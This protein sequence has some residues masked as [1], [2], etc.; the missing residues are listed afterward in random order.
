MPH[1]SPKD[2]IAFIVHGHQE[3]PK[4]AIADFLRDFT[5]LDPAIL[6]ELPKGSRTII[7]VLETVGSN[8][9]FAIVLLTG[10]DEGGISGGGNLQM[11]A[12]QNVIFELGLF[13]AML[14]RER[15]AVLYEPGVELPSDL[16]GVLYTP[17]DPAGGW[18]SS[19]ARELQ[20]AG[21][22]VDWKS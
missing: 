22:T 11:R 1:P 19:I 8:V 5:N 9:G 17:L 4:R 12:R 20:A 18:R 6:H 2:N 21:F 13:I 14:G 10:D 3:A 7:E 15:V 16:H